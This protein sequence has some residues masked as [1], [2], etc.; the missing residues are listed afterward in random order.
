MSLYYGTKPP[1]ELK[2]EVKPPELDA[3]A[4]EEIRDESEH[5]EEMIRAAVTEIKR[6]KQTQRIDGAEV[7]HRL[8][9]IIKAI[10][11]ANGIIDRV[12]E[13]Q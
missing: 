1:E 6:N 3:E 11:P 8:N 9:E 4:L 2:P 5:L 10:K 13:K 12:I 7:Y